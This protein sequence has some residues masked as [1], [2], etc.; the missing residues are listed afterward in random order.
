VF[1]GARRR[2]VVLAERQRR[3]LNS[4][5]AGAAPSPSAGVEIVDPW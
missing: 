5:T 3:L 2:L 1:P 4:S